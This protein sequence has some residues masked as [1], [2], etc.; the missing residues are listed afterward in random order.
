MLNQIPDLPRVP[1]CVY[2]HAFS[3]AVPR[4]DEVIYF[5][6]RCGFK[7]SVSMEEFNQYHQQYYKVTDEQLERARALGI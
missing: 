6:G 7:Q 2:C 5:C 4:H 1:A 3:I